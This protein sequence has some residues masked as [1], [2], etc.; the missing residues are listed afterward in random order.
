M[1][2]KNSIEDNPDL[3]LSQEMYTLASEGKYLCFLFDS[4]HSERFFLEVTSLIGMLW[5]QRKNWLETSRFTVDTRL[6]TTDS[7]ILNPVNTDTM[8]RA[9]GSARINGLNLEKM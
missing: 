8:Q 3:S 9:T 6:I 4:S 1:A 7:Q 2:S 5:N